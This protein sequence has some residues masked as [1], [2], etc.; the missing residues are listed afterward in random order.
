MNS[1]T[2]TMFKK[3]VIVGMGLMGGSLAAACRKEFPKTPIV[4]VTRNPKA[5]ALALKKK[6]IHEGTK[7]VLGGAQGADCVVICT[8]VDSYL[9]QLKKLDCV[10]ADRALVTD[11]G[12]VKKAIHDLVNARTWK[13]ISFVGAH[14]MVGSHER[15]IDFASPGLYKEGTVILTRDSKTNRRSFQQ[16]K[17][18][19]SRLSKKTVVLDPR[20]HDQFTAEISHLPHALVASLVRSVSTKSLSLA[21]AGFRDTTRV[22]ASDISIWQP[23]FQLNRRQFLLAMTRFEKELK[24]FKTILRSGDPAAL[25]RYLLRAQRI[26]Q[27]L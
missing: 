19:W 16:A 22:A 25:N 21:A 4:G 11:V 9:P 5:L 18:F 2:A 17:Y 23:I 15:G 24:H 14:P 3:I 7:D 12:S 8:P 13:R 10:V 6:W 27:S 1:E 20:A 26:R